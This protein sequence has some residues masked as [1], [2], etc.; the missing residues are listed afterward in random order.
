MSFV[1]VLNISPHSH[2]CFLEL[3]QLLDSLEKWETDFWQCP[4]C[5]YLAVDF[6]VPSLCSLHVARSCPER[7]KITPSHSIQPQVLPA[8]RTWPKLSSGIRSAASGTVKEEAVAGFW[9]V[10]KQIPLLGRQP[11]GI[12]SGLLLL[13]HMGITSTLCLVWLC[14]P[15][16]L[17]QTAGPDWYP[18]HLFSP[19]QLY[20]CF[21]F[22]HCLW[23][24]HCC[25]QPPWALSISLLSFT[26]LHMVFLFHL[27]FFF[28][29][30][31]LVKIHA[32]CILSHLWLSCCPLCI[33]CSIQACCC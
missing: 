17:L 4:G 19:K 12:L 16:W 23:Q 18:L 13:V 25:R 3:H 26:N 33:S 32:S 29:P 21:P 6:P 22:S 5:W 9:S 31:Q 1:I 10:R 30:F 8:V 28:F 27:P 24:R 2:A 11:C 20:S 7:T 15:S 14:L